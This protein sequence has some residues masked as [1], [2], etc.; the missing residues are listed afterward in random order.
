[1]SLEKS[2]IFWRGSA[3]PIYQKRVEFF[4]SLVELFDD[5]KYLEFKK[6][7]EQIIEYKKV[8]IKRKKKSD[9]F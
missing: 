9:F 7:I 8:E 2:S 3:V 6:H 5:F 1:M 4:E